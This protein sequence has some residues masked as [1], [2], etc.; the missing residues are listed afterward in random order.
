MSEA[1]IL[2][3]ESSP[4][5][6][7]KDTT[8]RI[9]WHVSLALLPAGLWGVY[10]FGIRSLLVIAVSIAA[11]AGTEYLIAR[12]QGK[13]TLSDG[14]AFLTGLLIGY[15]M[16][17][18]VPLFIP[19]VAS[20]FAIAVVKW[21]FGGLGGNWMNPA[22]AG[23]AFV[24][25]SWTSGMNAWKAPSTWVT[26][27]AAGSATPLGTVKTGLMDVSGEG[28][29]A[30]SYLGDIGYSFSRFGET[31]SG[32]FGSLGITLSPYHA[33]LF[34]GNIPGSIGEV[35][36]LLLILGGIYLLFKRIITWEIPVT[37]IL[38]F[39]LLVWVFE[40]TLFSR[41]LFSGSAAF[42]VF[43]GGLILGALFMATDM[44]TSP[45]TGRGMIIYGV[46]A[47]VLTFL[48][49]IYGSLPEG[50]S[51]AIII[52]NIFVPMI[53]RYIQPRPYGISRKKGGRT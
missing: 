26:V 44:V 42:H 46:G 24:F 16:P 50:V 37:Y 2:I 18:L 39:A 28:G 33:D 17:P 34:I 51:L 19:V 23:R 35:S 32:W 6:R 43:S 5:I 40:G 29:S 45:V 36:A 4:Q 53:D 3:V 31:V 1:N 25:F 21:V 52:M 11:A 15:N 20:V 14:S 22:L 38:S 13:N 8:A 27:D 30:L 7:H 9:M 48:I 47:G 10:V 12:L 41:G 49:R